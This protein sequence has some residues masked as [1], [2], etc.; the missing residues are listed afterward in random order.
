MRPISA[1]WFSGLQASYFY[2]VRHLLGMGRGWLRGFGRCSWAT[3][4]MRA[5]AREKKVFRSLLCACTRGVLLAPEDAPF[6]RVVSQS[7]TGGMDELGR[8]AKNCP[9]RGWWVLHAAT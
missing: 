3:F 2:A 9:A 4:G 8:D 1:F 6:E 5:F 7:E